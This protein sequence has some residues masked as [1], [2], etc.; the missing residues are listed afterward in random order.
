MMRRLS[1][2]AAALAIAAAFPGAANAIICYTV[3]DSKDTTIYQDTEPPFDMSDRGAADR[4]A[5]RARKEFMT[6]SDTDRCP[7][8]TAPP[9]TTTYRAA[10]VD[11]IVAGIRPYAGS[12][13]GPITTPAAGGRGSTRAA[14]AASSTRSSSSSPR[15]Y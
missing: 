12:G 10:T 8:I 13:S 2:L 15:R 5:M 4:E 6:I 9:G 3:L 7:L 1:I 11:E 14:P